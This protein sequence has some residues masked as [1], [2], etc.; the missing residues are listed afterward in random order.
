MA[1]GKATSAVPRFGGWRKLTMWLLGY[2]SFMGTALAA[3]ASVAFWYA[4]KP[5]ISELAQF[6]WVVLESWHTP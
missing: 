5:P 6:D 3:P 4:E 2:L 1:S